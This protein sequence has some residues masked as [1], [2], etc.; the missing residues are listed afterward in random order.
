VLVVA[1]AGVHLLVSSHA[2]STYVSTTANSGTFGG[3]S[4][5]QTCSGSSDGNCVV[6]GPSVL[7]TSSGH[8]LD[9][10]GNVMPRMKGFDIL[11][12]RNYSQAVYDS[13][14]VEGHC[15]SSNPCFQRLVVDWAAYQSTNCSAMTSSTTLQKANSFVDNSINYAANDDIYTEIMLYY[16]GKPDT[17]N[18]TPS[19][20]SAG[21]YYSQSTR[22]NTYGQYITQY[23]ANRYGNTSSPEYTTAV[24]GFGINEPDPPDG[25]KDATVNPA[26]EAMQ[27]TM[28]G[29]FRNK[30]SLGLGSGAPNWIGFVNY[31]YAQSSPLMTSGDTSGS[32]ATYE[33]CVSANP[34]A[35]NSVGGNVV[36]EVHDYF[37]DCLSGNNASTCDGRQWNHGG[38]DGQMY[39]TS[40]GGWAVGPDDRNNPA[41]PSSGVSPMQAQQEQANFMQPYAS[42]AGYKG[43]SGWPLMVGEWGWAP[44][45][46]GG[47]NTTGGKDYIDDMTNAWNNAGAAIELQWDYTNGTCSSDAYCAA[48]GG[49]WQPVT[50]QFFTDL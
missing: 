20:A 9:S 26:L 32:C 38:F 24:V 2:A 29:W 16:S 22:Y 36:L 50:N 23:L 41:Y 8:L 19:C 43:S 13:I 35:F 49:V 31:V 34:D 12:D 5:K 15:T 27:S 17:S 42:F 14:K 1:V 3:S 11:A 21:G 4:T 6:F 47:A 45:T 7:H 18:G 48:P 33:H 37:L 39:S 40:N 30:S 46:S 25:T 44:T 10:S 28:I